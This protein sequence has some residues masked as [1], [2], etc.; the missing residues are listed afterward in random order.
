MNV[1]KK[2]YI[3]A[4]DGLKIPI[5]LSMEEIEDEEVYIINIDG[6][7]WLVTCNKLH[8]IILFNMMKEHITEYM[9]YQKL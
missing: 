4:K 1:L 8:A 3:Q 6:V 7:E 2:D 9:T 5:T